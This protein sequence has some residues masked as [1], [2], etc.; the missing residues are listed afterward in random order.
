MTYNKTLLSILSLTFILISCSKDNVEEELKSSLINQDKIESDYS[1]AFSLA[2]NKIESYKTTGDI[3]VSALGVGEAIIDYYKIET[4]LDVSVEYQD[5]SEFID[6]QMDLVLSHIEGV[7]FNDSLENTETFKQLL[8]DVIISNSVSYKSSEYGISKLF[9]ELKLKIQN[10]I[11]EYGEYAVDNNNFDPD[12][13]KNKVYTAA[14]E[15]QSSVDLTT[16]SEIEKEQ[17]IY[18]FACIKASINELIN[19]GTSND[20]FKT[21]GF[22]K[23]TLGNVIMAT[24]AVGVGIGTAAAAI[25]GTALCGPGC[26]VAAATGSIVVGVYSFSVM[27]RVVRNN[28]GLI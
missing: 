12:V 4:G 17:F 1:K 16:Y 7:E 24:I 11:L 6:S 5:Q 27:S 28:W 13:L 19:L 23:R 10:T 20:S 9:A 15:F 2:L 18:A 21:S 3:Q 8:S 26:G 22:L 14:N 25:G